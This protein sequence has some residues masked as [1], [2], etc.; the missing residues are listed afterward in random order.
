MG[1]YTNCISIKQALYFDLFD[2][3]KYEWLKLVLDPSVDRDEYEF[4][5]TIEDL[6]CEWASSGFCKTKFTF[7][8]RKEDE[9]RFGETYYKTKT[10]TKTIEY[11]G[12]SYLAMTLC[13]MVGE[14][15]E[16]EEEDTD[17]NTEDIYTSN[18]EEEEVEEEEV[19]EEEEEEE[20]EEA[21]AKI[22]R[23]FVADIIAKVLS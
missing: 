15:S 5:V 20:E 19:E 9:V 2:D 12:S 10:F 4:D 23:T 8:L 21:P 17:T 22:A 13:G 6:P 1:K 18:N 3:I 11:N 14:D 16:D 7:E